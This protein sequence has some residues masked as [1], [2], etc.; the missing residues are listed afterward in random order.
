MLRKIIEWVKDQFSL[1]HNWHCTHC[2]KKGIVTE[3]AWVFEAICPP[4]KFP[5]N[6]SSIHQNWLCDKCYHILFLMDMGRYAEVQ[7]LLEEI[8]CSEK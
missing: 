4:I 5:L 8:P 6:R 1:T 3:I 7:K 2:G